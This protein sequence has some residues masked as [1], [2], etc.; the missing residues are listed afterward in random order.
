[1]TRFYLCATHHSTSRHVGIANFIVREPPTSTMM[2][3][4]GTYAR[5]DTLYTIVVVNADTS[6]GEYVRDLTPF[7]MQ[8]TLHRML[9]S[10]SEHPKERRVGTVMTVYEQDYGDLP[11]DFALQSMMCS[12]TQRHHTAHNDKLVER[13]C[14]D[15]DTY[16]ATL[17]ANKGHNGLALHQIGQMYRAS[18]IKYRTNSRL[19]HGDAR[20]PWLRVSNV[21]RGNTPIDEFLHSPGDTTRFD[22]RL[23]RLAE[24]LRQDPSAVYYP[25]EVGKILLGTSQS[26]LTQRSLISMAPEALIGKTHRGPSEF[27]TH[28]AHRR[29]RESQ[30]LP[31]QREHRAAKLR[32][33]TLPSNTVAPELATDIDIPTH[34]ITATERVQ[35]SVPTQSLS[36]G[37]SDAAKAK[38]WA[39]LFDAEPSATSSGGQGSTRVGPKS[40]ASLFTPDSSRRPSHKQQS[41]SHAEKD[42]SG[43]KLG[44]SDPQE[45]AYYVSA[46]GST[47]ETNVAVAQRAPR[48][49][50]AESFLAGHVG[51]NTTSQGRSTRSH[52]NEDAARSSS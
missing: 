33:G 38:T 45:T 34:D 36:E 35:R 46:R 7:Q 6:C 49:T 19:E 8:Q 28:Q 26:L 30:G 14:V 51:V 29:W 22:D 50:V 31:F 20:I 42:T 44:T 11:H 47:G 39:S 2:T 41:V 5:D 40:W 15:R 13:I 25:G 48:S 37:A 10:E 1:M 43:L 18:S 52:A 3:T 4:V 32:V 24:R 16:R 17:R 12:N 27:Q 9:E 21:G 23:Q